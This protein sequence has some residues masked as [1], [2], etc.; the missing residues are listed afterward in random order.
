[1]KGKTDAQAAACE[2]TEEAG[3][4]GTIN[5]EPIGRYAYDKLSLDGGSIPCVV[6]VYALRV[7]E[8][9]AK[10]REATTRTRSWIPLETASMLTYEEGLSDLLA[11]LDRNILAG[12]LPALRRKK[13]A[14]R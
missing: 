14:K 1:M 3:V 4:R 6:D 10:W 8:E 12:S 2:A 11:A 5:P 13:T 9:S 7:E